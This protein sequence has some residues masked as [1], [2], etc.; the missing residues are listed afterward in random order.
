MTFS[1]IVGLKILS[2][3]DK[4]ILGYVV[5][6][7]YSKKTQK[8][9]DLIVCDDIEETTKILNKQSILTINHDFVLITN[10]T[11]LTLAETQKPKCSDIV[12]KMAICVNGEIFGKIKS[13]DFDDTFNITSISTEKTEFTIKDIYGIGEIVFLKDKT[14][15]RQ[16]NFAPKK[17]I[18]KPPK[19]LEQ[20][21]SVEPTTPISVKVQPNGL[22]GKRLKRDFIVLGN[23]ILARKNTTITSDLILTAK[24]LNALKELELLSF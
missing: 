1:D 23:R 3:Y 6:A 11:V 13:I 14:K 10:S 5:D 18:E 7:L 24:R 20:I 4:K 17:K 16:R 8:I 12:N 22:I 9:T 15:T 21:V 19:K 2:V